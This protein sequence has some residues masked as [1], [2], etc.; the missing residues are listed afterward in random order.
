MRNQ[1]WE[2]QDPEA[3]SRS[4]SPQEYRRVPRLE[5]SPMPRMTAPLNIKKYEVMRGYSPF[6]VEDPLD[7]DGTHIDELSK[8]RSYAVLGTPPRRT[9]EPQSDQAASA[10]R[11]LAALPRN[12]LDVTFSRGQREDLSRDRI[13]PSKAKRAEE[14]LREQELAIEAFERRLDSDALQDPQFM[15][16]SP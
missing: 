9:H 10:P 8:P 11:I 2:M 5:Y 16:V 12:A 6:K 13:S 7:D 15:L 4:V 3:V 1:R 14:Q